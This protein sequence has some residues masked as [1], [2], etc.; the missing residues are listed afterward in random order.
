MFSATRERLGG[1]VE[2]VE[3]GVLGAAVGVGE[4]VARDA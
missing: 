2:G 1:R 4:L 3:V